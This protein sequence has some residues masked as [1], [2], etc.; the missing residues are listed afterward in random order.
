MPRSL[1]RSLSWSQFIR[2]NPRSQHRL[3][4]LI[5]GGAQLCLQ[6]SAELSVLGG[7]RSSTCPYCVH[8]GLTAS[9]HLNCTTAYQ[10]LIWPDLRARACQGLKNEL[11]RCV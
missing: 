6:G 3:R 4:S 10:S 5:T 8:T 1:I 11:E 2:D 7:P 9:S